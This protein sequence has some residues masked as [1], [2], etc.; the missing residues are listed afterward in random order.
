MGDIGAAL[1]DMWRSVLLFLPKAI[2]F[3]AILVVGWLIAAAVRK[4]VDKTL[5][6]VGF[7]RAV[8]RGGIG[9]ALERSRYDASDILARLA[10]YAILLLTLQ[11]AFG[12]WG[13]NPVSDLIAAVV[14]WLP[15]AFV[16]ILI[17]VVAAAIAHAVKDL[18]GGALGGLTYGRFLANLASW[19]I[20]GLGAI[21]ALNQVGIATT[22]TTPVLIAALATI[23]G[24]LIVGVGGGLVRPM[25]ER[26]DRWLDRAES[27]SQVIR[28]RAMAY[29]A[30]RER[31]D[32]GRK[33]AA[34]AT[35]VLPQPTGAPAGPAAVPPGPAEAARPGEAAPATTDPETTM[36]V[37]T[38][39]PP[40]QTYQSDYAPTGAEEPVSSID[41][42]QRI[43][44]K[45]I[46]PRS[47][48]DR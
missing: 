29:A 44:T 5:E 27:E 12:V 15:K 3:V 10:Y 21:A 9:R 11:F 41:D 36:V 45:Q 24:I 8:E 4:F 33:L 13:P 31:E 26:W 37:P 46:A 47:G 34:D 25:S 35:E 18:I 2:A 16:A 17:V 48:S 38:A 23:A 32:L 14:A 43:D 7:D 1:T 39:V 30:A 42:T 40:G 22:V 20:I 28:E 19:F 6:R